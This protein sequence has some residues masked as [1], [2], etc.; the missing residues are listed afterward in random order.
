MG[1]KI[2]TFILN[3]LNNEHINIDIIPSTINLIFNE[4]YVDDEIKVL[5]EKIYAYKN[6]KNNIENR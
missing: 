2:A 6:N 1:K 3:L 4:N 5:H